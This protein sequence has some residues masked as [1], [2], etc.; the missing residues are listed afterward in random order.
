MGIDVHH[1]DGTVLGDGAKNRQ[2]DGMITAR[3]QGHHTGPVHG[4][5]ERLDVVEAGL[6]VK[7]ALHPGIA[8][9]GHPAL[10]HRDQMPLA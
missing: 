5:E 6:E 8:D 10:H 4:I 3:R 9:V 1:T 7:R 2:R